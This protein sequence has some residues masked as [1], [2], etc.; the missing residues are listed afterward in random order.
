ML[1]INIKNIKVGP[2]TSL[3]KLTMRRVY[4]ECWEDLTNDKKQAILD[5][6]IGVTDTLT[7]YCEAETLYVKYNR[8]KWS[9]YLL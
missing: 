4:M 3:D 7:V 9:I 8:G 6:R 5:L 2:C 1:Q